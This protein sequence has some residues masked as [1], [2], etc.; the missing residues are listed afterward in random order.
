M[1]IDADVDHG[2]KLEETPDGTV[3]SFKG[4]GLGAFAL[5]VRSIVSFLLVFAWG[6]GLLFF[7]Y[8]FLQQYSRTRLQKFVFDFD[9]ITI[10]GKRY[11][12]ANISQVEMRND[13]SKD[14]RLTGQPSFGAV[15]GGTGIVGPSVAATAMAGSAM[16]NAAI[17]VASMVDGA[18]AKRSF[19]V[20][21][22]Y[23][24]DWIVV[25]KYLSEGKAFAIFRL[26]VGE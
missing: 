7:A 9:S 16:G 8:F 19:R 20:R 13:R 6:I 4:D 5:A 26:L 2:Y 25:G 10:D 22:R 21:V 12:F 24:K 14:S 17:G 3:V 11:K 15:V 1:A 23:G 18:I